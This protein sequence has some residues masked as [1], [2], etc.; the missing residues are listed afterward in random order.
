MCSYFITFP[1]TLSFFD[2]SEIQ[3]QMFKFSNWQIFGI[4]D[5]CF[6]T[7]K[8]FHPWLRLRSW[9]C[10]LRLSP[11]ER[12]DLHT[13]LS[14]QCEW[15]NLGHQLEVQNSQTIWLRIRVSLN[16]VSALVVQPQKRNS[17]K[18]FFW[19]TQLH[20]RISREFFLK[21]CCILAL[22]WQQMQLWDPCWLWGPLSSSR[23]VPCST[24]TYKIISALCKQ[25]FEENK[26][27]GVIVKLVSSIL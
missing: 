7:D 14:P 26:V 19:D 17:K 20:M 5:K 2:A 12:L 21:K 24:I 27:S 11:R 13:K 23:Q 22:L 4:D 3:I 6:F 10:R 9:R 1:K 15:H 25:T 16:F 8:C 18:V